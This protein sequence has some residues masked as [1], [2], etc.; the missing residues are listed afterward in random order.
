MKS[1][2]SFRAASLPLLILFV[3]LGIALLNYSTP[4]IAAQETAVPTALPDAA[5]GLAIYNERCAV[6]HGE[7]GDGL[8]QQAVQA[9]LQPTAFADPNYRLTADPARMFEVIN[10]GNL[11]NGMPPFRCGQQQPIEREPT[12]GT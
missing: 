1:K 7:M 5:A 8:G 2:D 4:P 11:A 12:F 10:N 9:G 6:C 3:A